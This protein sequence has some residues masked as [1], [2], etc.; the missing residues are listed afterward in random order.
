MEDYYSKSAATKGKP[1]DYENFYTSQAGGRID[2]YVSYR[3]L[4]NQRGNGFFGRLIS[5]S[6]LPLIQRVLPYLS[7]K[8]VEGVEG[9][10]KDVKDGI[11]IKQSAKNQL[12]R[13]AS[14]VL[15]DMASKISPQKGSG[16][17]RKHKTSKK[18]TRRC[19]S[20]KSPARPGRRRTRKKRCVLFA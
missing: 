6:I 5:G 20:R 16:L 13:S 19:K 4:P 3:Y 2:P 17:R 18:R 1:A 7:S 12:K 9:I 11:S 8:T 10:V 15:Q 14:S